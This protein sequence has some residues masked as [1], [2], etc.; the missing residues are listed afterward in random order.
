MST[1]V[2][3]LKIGEA[4]KA[5][6][7]SQETLRRWEKSGK[8]K[9]TRTPGGTRLYSNKE[10]NRLL[11]KKGEKK[12]FV[13]AKTEAV[14]KR[15]L[16][17]WAKSGNIPTPK[18]EYLYS[19]LN[20]QIELHYSLTSKHKLILGI[21]TIFLLAFFSVLPVINTKAL[22]QTVNY[23]IPKNLSLDILRYSNRSNSQDSKAVAV[24]AQTH[25]VESKQLDKRAEILRDY[26]T[27]FNSPLQYH[28][29]D[30]VDAADTYNVDWKLLASISGVESTFGTKI[31]GGLNPDYSSFNGWGW[32]VYGTKAVYFDSWRQALFNVSKGLKNGYMDKGLTNPYAMNSKYSSS[33]F[34]GNSVSYFMSDLEE[35][36]KRYDFKSSPQAAILSQDNS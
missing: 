7:V 35:F 10:I 30:L 28:A 19:I 32:G 24:F 16:Y 13:T 8:I 2:Q 18:K 3:L 26:L 33:P 15:T 31:P 27:Q 1:S 5:L 6:N 29:Q 34:W 20:Y 11:Q 17:R 23:K 14:S 22:A 36:A 12:L 9:V 21:F 4:A 25:L